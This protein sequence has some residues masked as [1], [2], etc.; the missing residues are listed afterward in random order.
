MDDEG[1]M[2]VHVGGELAERTDEG[3][4]LGKA[5]CPL[6]TGTHHELQVVHHHV[7]DVV[8]VHG[9]GHGL[10]KRKKQLCSSVLFSSV[11]FNSRDYLL[12]H[13]QE[14]P[15]ARHPIFWKFPNV[16]F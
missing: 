1:D 6:P 11:L 13:N 8:D 15:Y 5:V 4:L 9:M 7:G 2:A 12:L 10:G 16:A 14:S 3:V